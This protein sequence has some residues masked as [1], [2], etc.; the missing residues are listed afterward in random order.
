[1][2]GKWNRREEVS[3]LDQIRRTLFCLSMRKGE[4]S[5]LTGDEWP[6]PSKTTTLVFRVLKK[7]KKVPFNLIFYRA[8]FLLLNAKNQRNLSCL[9][10][11]RDLNWP[12]WW[13]QKNPM[14]LLEK[15]YKGFLNKRTPS[16]GAPGRAGEE[17]SSF[18]L[19]LLR[20]WFGFDSPLVKLEVMLEL[21]KT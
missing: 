5:G 1:M 19:A 14:T 2:E 20:G 10:W 4:R 17:S 12:F 21:R 7:S 16:G 18:F 8:H 13:V 11:P 9:P 6:T 15:L 3:F